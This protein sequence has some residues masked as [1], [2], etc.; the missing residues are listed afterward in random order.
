MNKATVNLYRVMDAMKQLEGELRAYDEATGEGTD[1]PMR[2]AS[3]W[4]RA[5]FRKM[6][7]DEQA[8]IAQLEA[9][10]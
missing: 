5:Q 7:A 8:H 6:E 1:V 4:L 2:A 9:T 10:D 3:L